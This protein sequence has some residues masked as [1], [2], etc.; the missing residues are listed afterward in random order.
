M[1]IQIIYTNVLNKDSTFDYFPKN[2]GDPVDPPVDPTDPP[3]DPPVDP[4]DPPVEPPINPDD[5]KSSTATIVASVVVLAVVFG[6][7]TVGAVFVYKKNAKVFL[8]SE[9]IENVADSVPSD[10]ALD[11]MDDLKVNEI[12]T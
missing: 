2:G 12:V 1:Y 9:V 10:V 5:K 6:L 4:T 8:L 7:G 11:Q 3:V